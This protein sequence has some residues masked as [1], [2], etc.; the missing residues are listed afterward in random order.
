MNVAVRIQDELQAA[1]S[2]LTRLLAL[3]EGNRL[4]QV[5]AR[6][7]EKLGLDHQ[8]VAQARAHRLRP[9]SNGGFVIDVTCGNRMLFIEVASGNLHDLSATIAHRHKKQQNRLGQD[10]PM[11][12]H[13]DEESASTVRLK[14]QDELI[15]GLPATL[16]QGQFGTDEVFQT[17]LLAHRLNRR[18][19][20][21]V[22]R[23]DDT[24]AVI[25]AY[26]RGSQKA[27]G[28]LTLHAMLGHTAF[29]EKSPVR[30]PKITA[31]CANWPGYMM[32]YVRGTAVT[33]L[34][35]IARHHGMRLAGEALGRLHRLPLRL[36]SQYSSVDE[37]KLLQSWILL[38][39]QLFPHRT[40]AL[41]QA[42]T[43]VSRL[44]ESSQ[45][46]AS[47][48]IVH[49]DF[50]EGQVLV[51]NETATLIDFDTACNGEPAQDV[52]NFLAHLDFA[53]ELRG[54]N[55]AVDIEAFLKSYG[56]AHTAIPEARIRAH[57]AATLLRLSCIHAISI[58]SRPAAEALT[59]RALSL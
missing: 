37:L 13:V 32:E 29:S 24:Q 46:D 26:K 34:T 40:S 5:V 6:A 58:D 8:D 10:L 45:A 1:P 36:E 16:L 23:G 41:N 4:G 12:V 43:H 47:E 20:I 48:C 55:S 7:A 42:L 28:A 17:R 25:K 21:G 54:V 15:D 19:V 49:R 44:F 22:T 14:G 52:G 59:E 33:E 39:S 35:G 3:L 2:P 30:V 38:A 57:R 31:Q 18:V 27:D 56:T 51:A 11:L 9:R 53:E 50:H